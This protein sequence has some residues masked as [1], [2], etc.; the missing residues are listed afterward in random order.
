MGG[1]QPALL[2]LVEPRRW[3]R[4]QDHFA[5]VLGIAIRTVTPA[6]ELLVAPSWPATLSADQV[7]SALK[8]G[9]ELER[10]LPARDLPH[11]S[12][13]LTTRLGVT[14]ASVP[15][16]VTDA[17]V[18][19]Y[20]VVGPMIVGP[21]EDELQ[22]RQRVGAMGLDAPTLWA[23]LL[24]LKLYTFSGIRSVLSLME[25]VGTSLA[26][27]ASQ[28]K[29]LPA[30]FPALLEA[31]ILATRAEGGSV[32]LYDARREALQ[33]TVAHGLSDDV[34]VGTRLTRGEGIAGLAAEKRAILLVDAQTADPGV[35]QRMHRS[36]LTSS[37]VAALPVDAA[38][39]PLGV[40]NLR[41][42]N[43]QRPFSVEHVELLRR[44]LDIAGAALGSLRPAS[45]QPTS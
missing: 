39:E 41:T 22:F 6:H 21:R 18:L 3:Q 32:M 33:I 37:L 27:L 4:L 19:A 23:L 10:L 35:R 31:A 16:R 24:S 45:S 14:Y 9:E 15:I 34:V 38:Q 1:S 13:S 36:H 11:E 5:G 29:R 2:D 40:L 30:V 43:P 17:E 42:T 12:S 20:F 7:V 8:V 25:D 28:A 44:L 26:Q